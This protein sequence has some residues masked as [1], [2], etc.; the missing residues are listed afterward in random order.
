MRAL[1][2]ASR[3]DSGRDLRRRSARA[4]LGGS[5]ERSRGESPGAIHGHC[6]HRRSESA[7][8]HRVAPLDRVD[9]ARRDVRAHKSIQTSG[10]PPLRPRALSR[11]RRDL[12]AALDRISS[13]RLA[14]AARKHAFRPAVVA[15]PRVCAWIRGDQSKPGWHLGIQRREIANLLCEFRSCLLPDGHDDSPTR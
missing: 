8:R 13:R 10:K 7:H 15:H 11:G 2:G 3:H 6:Q 12:L 1:L 5:T 14:G 9:R 4:A